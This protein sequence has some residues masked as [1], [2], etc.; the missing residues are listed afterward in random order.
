MA[1]DLA[2]T[3]KATKP[4]SAIVRALALFTASVIAGVCVG[5]LKAQLASGKFLGRGSARYQ[6]Q[7]IAACEWFDLDGWVTHEQPPCHLIRVSDKSEER[8]R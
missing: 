4:A 3:F 5:C 2:N 8:P 6:V 1:E 7:Q